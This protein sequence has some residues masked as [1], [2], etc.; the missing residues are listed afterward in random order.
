METDVNGRVQVT[1]FDRPD[2]RNAMTP[3]AARE[4]RDAIEAAG[5]RD[6]RALVITGSGGSFCAGGDLESMREREETPD[7]AARRVRETLNANVRAILSAP[8]P[9]IAKVNGDAIGAGTNLAAA[10]DF[11]YADADARFGEAF[12]NVGLVPDTGGTVL[13]PRLVGLR[14]AKELTMTGRLFDADEAASMGLI[15]EAVSGDA[16]DERVDELLETLDRKPTTT[17][18]LIKEGIHGNLG[19]PVDDALDREAAL[20]VRAYGTDAHEEGVA[21]FLDDRRPDFD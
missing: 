4:L 3:A 16:L 2:A 1:R 12:V 17:L 10:C 6:V 11:A 15:N 8:F 20:Q 19:R 21:A 18:G 13:L 7:E 14:R 5:E 9:V